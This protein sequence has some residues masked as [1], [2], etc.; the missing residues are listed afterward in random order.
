MAM[1]FDLL[2]QAVTG[3]FALAAS[4]LMR[5]RGVPVGVFGWVI[6]LLFMVVL[7]P[8]A[9]ELVFRGVLFPALRFTLGAWWALVMC[10][11]FHAAFHFLAYPPAADDQTV[12]LWYGLT[13][14][15][16]DALV[17][18][19]VRAY[20]GSTRAAIVAHA[21]FGLFAVLKVFFIAG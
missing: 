7:Q 19:A 12:L 5:F 17:I 3:D 6:A 1:T 11:G 20:T 13:L 4:E 8:V 15:F 21:A 18:T 2:S 10:A 14:P 16:L 9:E